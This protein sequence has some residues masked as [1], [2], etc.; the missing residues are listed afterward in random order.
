[1]GA[2]ATGDVLLFVLLTLLFVML[3]YETRKVLKVPSSLMLLMA[4]VFLR[5]A[6]VYIGSVSGAVKLWD[7]MDQWPVL[8]ILLPALI[9]ETAF[10]TDWYTFKRELGQIM[11]LATSAVFLSSILTGFSIIYILKYDFDWSEAICLG[12]ILSATDHVAVVSQ[13]KEVNAEHRLETLIQGETLLNE[14]SVMVIFFLMLDNITGHNLEGS[15]TGLFFRLALGGF[16]LGLTFGIVMTSV[17]KHIV[18]DMLLETNLTLITAYLIFYTAE[19]TPLHVSGAIATVTFGLYMSAYGKTL[20]SPNVEHTVH[21]FWTI[22]GKNIEAVL[23]VIA[24]ILLGRYFFNSEISLADVG[25]MLLL[26]VILHVVRGLVILI[27]YP[28]LRRIGYGLNWKEAIVLTVGALKGTIAI[29]LGLIV[30]R[31]ENVEKKFQVICLFF[32]VGICALSVCFD[33]IIVLFVV[34]ALGLSSFSSV[35][36]HMLLQVTSSILEETEQQ[37]KILKRRQ[38]LADWS[39]VKKTAGSYN[40]LSKVMRST[41]AGRATLKTC[42]ETSSKKVLANFFDR[43]EFTTFDLECEMRRRYLTTLKGLYWHEFEHGQCFGSSALILI[44]TTN[45]CLDNFSKPME[46]WSHAEASV[47]ANWGFRLIRKLTKVPCIGQLFHRFLYEQLMTAYDVA[48]TFIHCHKEAKD[49]LETMCFDADEETMDIIFSENKEQV[50]KAKEFIE[51][52]INDNFPEVISHVQTKK[53]AFA[54]LYFQRTTAEEC[55]EEGVVDAKERNIIIEAIDVSMKKLNS[56]GIPKMPG[57]EEILAKSQ[58][59]SELSNSERR[60]FLSQ[61]SQKMFHP[62]DLLFLEDERAT[63]AYIVLQGRVEERSFNWIDS[64]GVGKLVGEHNLLAEV[65]FNTT[66]AEAKTLVSAAFIPKNSEIIELIEENIWKLAT[67][68]RLVSGTM[69]RG[70][71]DFEIAD[72]QQLIDLSEVKQY[73]SGQ[74][75]ALNSGGILLAGLLSCSQKAPCYVEP[76][77]EYVQAL[78]PSSVLHFNSMITLNLSKGHSIKTAMME[79]EVSTGPQFLRLATRNPSKVVASLGGLV[80]SHVSLRASASVAPTTTND[81]LEVSRGEMLRP[82]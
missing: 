22:I 14:G 4:G 26:F 24:G 30:Y 21:S 2:G 25:M 8:L 76:T 37:Q 1:M 63:G 75:V 39:E 23:F 80:K 5:T 42:T 77:R 16:G 73:T 33:S 38:Q 40:L 54:L 81:D 45:Y 27:H 32:S 71:A 48:N 28:V 78:S 36:E 55:F 59:I 74:E 9:F 68:K 19:A 20:I 12:A 6:G 10:T 70:F 67:A 50:K 69:L 72:F 82:N 61:S 60:S 56:S 18:N 3:V 57:L 51:T 15:S 47:Y 35:Q 52:Q 64:Y 13:L 49:L 11:F 34:R 41:K 31:S 43:L 53:A 17:L 65:Q 66:T 44:E 7:N 62:G 58:F 29:A 46:D 79:S